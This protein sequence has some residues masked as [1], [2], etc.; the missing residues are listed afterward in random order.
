MGR[1]EVKKFQG[2][3]HE[4]GGV[5]KKGTRG[6]IRGKEKREKDRKGW[7]G[8]SKLHRLT[9]APHD[10]YDSRVFSFSRKV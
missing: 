10:F 5:G 3:I 2:G 9:S 7:E 1:R 8:V 6:T 4:S